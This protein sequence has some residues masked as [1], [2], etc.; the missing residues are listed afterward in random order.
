MGLLAQ[1]SFPRL[2]NLKDSKRIQEALAGVHMERWGER[3]ITELSGGQQQR[4]LI[5]KAL[6][7][8][9]DVLIL[10]EPTTGIDQE[11][12]HSFYN[13]L[14]R[15]H[16]GGMTIVLVTHDIGRITRHVTKVASINQRLTF[17]GNHKEFCANNPEHE[18]SLCLDRG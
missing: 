6:V 4:V 17:Y 2:M 1:K 11:N 9:P 5:A 16:T 8:R 7:T 15:L 3:R 12:Q 14:G 10:D 13:L 18:H